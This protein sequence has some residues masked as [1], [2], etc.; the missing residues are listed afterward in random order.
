MQHP[1]HFLKNNEGAMMIV[2]AVMLLALMTVISITA[3]K[4]ANTEVKIASNEYLHQ[5]NFYYAEGAALEAF[6]H[7]EALGEISNGSIEWLMARPG[8]INFDDHILIYWNAEKQ[9]GDAIPKKASLGAGFSELIAVHHGALAGNSLDMS[10][11]TKHVFSIYGKSAN[12]G[13]VIIRLGYSK[14]Y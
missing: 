3:L 1:G 9:A 14:I 10:K 5:R 11:P 12:Q 6:D 2:M 4:T 13:L 8:L 7:L